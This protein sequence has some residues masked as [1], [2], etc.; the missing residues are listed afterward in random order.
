MRWMPIALLVLL[1]APSCRA[2]ESNLV[3]TMGRFE[4][5]DSYAQQTFSLGNTTSN[6]YEVVY[7]ECGFFARDSLI[8][9]E[10]GLIQNLHPGETGY[11]HV[12]AL[13]AGDADSAKCRI[14]EIR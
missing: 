2:K 8:A 10:S 6:F 5:A 4:R 7:V 3:L 12:I 11:G 13:K 1:A 14:Q 9:S